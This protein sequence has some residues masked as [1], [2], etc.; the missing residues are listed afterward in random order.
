MYHCERAV[1]QIHS[2]GNNRDERLFPIFY[3]FDKQI[4]FSIA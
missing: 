4:Y 3:I 1:V 2:M